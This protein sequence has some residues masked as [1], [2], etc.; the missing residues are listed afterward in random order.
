MSPIQKTI[1]EPFKIDLDL[2]S[3]LK[4]LYFYVAKPHYCEKGP[5]NQRDKKLYQFIMYLWEEVRIKNR[6]T[7]NEPLKTPN[8]LKNSPHP[9]MAQ[10]ADINKKEIQPSFQHK[11]CYGKKYD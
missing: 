7:S 6:Q 5:D 11:M 9:K 10:K 3:A 8:F 4:N 1:M 2:V